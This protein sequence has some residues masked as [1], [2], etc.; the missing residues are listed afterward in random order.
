MGSKVRQNQLTRQMACERTDLGREVKAITMAHQDL[1]G[2]ARDGEEGNVGGSLAAA[3]DHD[4]LVL[5][6][7]LAGFEL[8]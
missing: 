1:L 5:A 4:S 6:E 3:H 7:L 2:V 8:R